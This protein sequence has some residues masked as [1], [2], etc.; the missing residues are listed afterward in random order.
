M[1]SISYPFC[2][3]LLNSGFPVDNK[4]VADKKVG[5][6]IDVTTGKTVN[7][8]KAGIIDPALVTKTALKNAVSV[9]LTIMSADCVISNKRIEYASGK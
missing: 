1:D 5:N 8:T 4:T 9:A 2:R 3:I 6:G 7:M